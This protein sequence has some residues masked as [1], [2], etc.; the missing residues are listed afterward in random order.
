[1]GEEGGERAPSD[2]A[3]PDLSTSR[4]LL[5]SILVAAT[6]GSGVVEGRCT[7][8][9]RLRRI[10]YDQTRPQASSTQ[11]L[12]SDVRGAA[13]WSHFTMAVRS[14]GNS[15]RAAA[16]PVRSQ[17]GGDVLREWLNLEKSQL[18]Y[19]VFVDGPA[20]KLTR[21]NTKKKRND[22]TQ[23]R[24]SQKTTHTQFFFF[25]V[26]PP[27]KHCAATS[28]FSLELFREQGCSRR[29]ILSVVRD[30]GLVKRRDCGGCVRAVLQ[31]RCGNFEIRDHLPTLHT[32]QV[33]CFDALPCVR[34]VR[35]YSLHT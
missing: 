7:Q 29:R 25:G 33:C 17:V 9:P 18:R 1:M 23:L 26:A 19:G 32:H 34:C 6:L 30:E 12:P 8:Q 16:G 27:E 20:K 11:G 28:R 15:D 31:Q 10:Q 14:L 22:V 2:A 4:A 21:L 13:V 24:V 35:F 5:V 3:L